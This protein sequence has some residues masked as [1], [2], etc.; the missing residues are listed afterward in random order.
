MRTQSPD[1][2]PE[3]ERVLIE[4]LRKAP[5]WRK[6]QLT[7]RMGNFVR[8]L[9]KVWI[10]DRFPHASEA[11]LRRHFA[12]IHLGRELAAKVYGPAPR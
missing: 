3:A 1:T 8:G 7:D 12:D 2:N 11:E 9:C 10:R 5:A 4:L 6:L